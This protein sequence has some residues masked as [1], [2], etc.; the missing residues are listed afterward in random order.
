MSAEKVARRIVTAMRRGRREI[1]L[2]AGGKALVWL[3]R[4]CPPLA[5]WIIARWG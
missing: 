2:S 1:I 4:L 5:D 3:D